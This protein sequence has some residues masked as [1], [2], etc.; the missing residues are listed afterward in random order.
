MG[1]QD[2]GH[3][4]AGVAG[5]LFAAV[6]CCALSAVGAA[7][8]LAGRRSP[9]GVLAL[10]LNALVLLGTGAGLLVVFGLLR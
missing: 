8:G 5:M 9:V 3:W 6:G 7:F 4:L 2:P 1:T 10:V